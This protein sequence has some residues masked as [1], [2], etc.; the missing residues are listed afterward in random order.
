MDLEL[1]GSVHGVPTDDL[2]LRHIIRIVVW[3]QRRHERT[4]EGVSSSRCCEKERNP[5]IVPHS[6]WRQTKPPL[7]IP[8]AESWRDPRDDCHETVWLRCIWLHQLH[9][10]AC[11]TFDFAFCEKNHISHVRISWAMA[12]K[13]IVQLSI[14]NK[15]IYHM[16]GRNRTQNASACKMATRQNAHLLTAEILLN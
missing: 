2:C 14:Q 9:T 4:I 5:S 1:A 6:I 12:T 10:R 8:A 7:S 3:F 13:W 15:I 16:I 11:V